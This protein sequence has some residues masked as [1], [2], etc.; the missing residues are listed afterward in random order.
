MSFSEQLKKLKKDLEKEQKTERKRHI[1]QVS[2]P[3]PKPVKRPEATS[4]EPAAPPAP[5]LTDAQL[6][7][8]SLQ[9]IDQNAVYR[10]KFGD[11]HDRWQP[12]EVKSRHESERLDAVEAEARQFVE[13]LREKRTF[14]DMVG[15]LDARF[16]D[17]KFFVPPK[18]RVQ[19]TPAVTGLQTESLG[20]DP[21]GLRDVELTPAHRDL[22]KRA[23]VYAK[24][25]RLPELNLR[26]KTR[27]EAIERLE[28]FLD[29]CARR[30]DR[31]ARVIHGKGKQS[32]DDP[33]LKPAVLTW[34]EGP[35]AKVVQG[36][37]PEITADGD[38]G[39]LMLEF[40]SK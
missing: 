15:K 16:S 31:F 35:G 9:N 8:Q 11:P 28:A 1:E 26:G 22:L 5:V 10:G 36:Y 40:R 18:P 14:E 39:V 3:T 33:V 34:C 4:A 12:H 2:K 24:E 13:E 7:E 21:K 17:D 25:R 30:D 32:E 6:F 27:D 37:A 20:L 29:I 23:G 38:Y 19:V